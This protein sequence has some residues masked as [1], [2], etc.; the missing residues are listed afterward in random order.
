[1]L[2]FFEPLIIFQKI[3]QFTR[4]GKKKM[5]QFVTVLWPDSKTGP[6]C[7]ARA[8]VAP[9]Q[10]ATWAR[11]KKAAHPLMPAWA[12]LR[13][14]ASTPLMQI[15]WPRAR[16]DGSKPATVTLPRNPSSLSSLPFLS[17]QCRDGEATTKW[18]RRRS[19]RQRARSPEAERAAVEWSGRRYP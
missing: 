18:H 19:L 1:M 6:A 3:K 17:L 5:V 14:V 12:I 8:R 4:K 2:F 13:P 11:A 15:G 16:L 9:S 7:V 10:A